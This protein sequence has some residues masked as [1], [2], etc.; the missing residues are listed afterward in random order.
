VFDI[1]IVSRGF[2]AL[3]SCMA[4]TPAVFSV[5]PYLESRYFPVTRDVEVV[6]EHISDAGTS[7]YVRFDKVRRCDFDGLAW[8]DGN[9]RLWVDFEPGAKRAPRTRPPGDQYA[10]P[11]FVE[12]LQG[13][14][15][16]RAFVYHRCHP[17]WTTITR[18]FA[19]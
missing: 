6:Q 2:V 10:G 4:L 7:F 14:T 3:A 11:W 17:L 1:A 9:R 18:F 15:G 16:S 5:G 8:Y 19:A 13:T 12:G